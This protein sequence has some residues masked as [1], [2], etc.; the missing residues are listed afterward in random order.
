M[1]EHKCQ[2]SV[3][4]NMERTLSRRIVD[5]LIPS[6]GHSSVRRLLFYQYECSGGGYSLSFGLMHIKPGGEK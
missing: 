5:K 2:I 3:G 4:G 1:G 6:P